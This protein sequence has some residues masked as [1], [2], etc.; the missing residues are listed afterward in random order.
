MRMIDADELLERMKTIENFS[1]QKGMFAVVRKMVENAPTI[2]PIK[3]GHW[4]SCDDDGDSPYE[5][6]VCGG[7][8]V[9]ENGEWLDICHIEWSKMPYCA[10]C[11]AKMDERET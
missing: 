10:V 3:H 6:S 8:K 7:V 11:G 5:C 9:N 2:D 4:I 1:N